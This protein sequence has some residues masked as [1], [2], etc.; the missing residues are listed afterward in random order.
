MQD[1]T[2]KQ[3]PPAPST[4]AEVAAHIALTGN[5]AGLTTEQ[6]WEYYQQYCDHLGLNPI[7]K[8]FDLITTYDQDGTERT[9][10]Y[11]NASCA[12]QLADSR[13]IRYGKPELELDDQL[14][15]LSV[16]VKAYF[17]NGR[18]CWR[19]GVADVRNLKGKYL[20]NA[21]KKA[22]TQ[23][24]RRATL[25]LC[26]VAMPDES[27][28]PDI[29]GANIMT[30]HPPAID[31]NRL[32]P[33]FDDPTRIAYITIGQMI[34]ESGR[35][36]LFDTDG[37]RLYI[38]AGLRQGAFQAVGQRLNRRTTEMVEIFGYLCPPG[39]PPTIKAMPPD[40]IKESMAELKKHFPD[41]DS[42]PAPAP[43]GVIMI[44]PEIKVEIEPAQA[45]TKTPGLTK[46]DDPVPLKTTAQGLRAEC[47]DLA[48]AMYQK[49]KKTLHRDGITREAFLTRISKLIGQ[50][51]NRFADIPE[52]LL[53]TVYD[54]LVMYDR[55]LDEN[56]TGANQVNGPQFQ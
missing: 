32:H 42:E 21:I 44:T 48:N 38:L 56:A 47:I 20:E 41:I 37:E 24:H 16:I 17:V 13:D 1:R 35:P 11:A 15:V 18:E 46:E 49:Y 19:R 43:A 51:V 22:E 26:G 36:D 6:R 4:P 40:E 5:L 7:T 45:Q 12:V 2:K 33:D 9:V 10:L 27:E 55:E 54:D 39:E 8:P 34:H 30:I 29:E 28:L 3:L 53:Q 31:V 25:A 52:S 50:K 14:G 23:A